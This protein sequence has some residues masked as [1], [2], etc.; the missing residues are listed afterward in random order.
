MASKKAVQKRSKPSVEPRWLLVTNK[1]R[2][3]R[4]GRNETWKPGD[5]SIVLR[6]ARRVFSYT[7]GA[8]RGIDSLATVGPQAGSKVGPLVS[9]LSDNDVSTV[10]VCDAASREAWKKATW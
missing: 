3:I 7:A 1:Q 6:E 2:G 5:T 4:Y 8:V 10:V 9:E